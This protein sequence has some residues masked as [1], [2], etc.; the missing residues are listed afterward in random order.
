MSIKLISLSIFSFNGKV[1]A[2]KAISLSVFSFSLFAF[3]VPNI[4][5]FSFVNFCKNIENV[6]MKNINIVVPFSEAI[7][8]TFLYI[9]L[10]RLNILVL[11]TFLLMF[12]LTLSKG[13][14]VLSISPFKFSIQKLLCLLNSSLS[15]K[16]F[17]SNEYIEYVYGNSKSTFL[18]SRIS[19]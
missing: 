11:P 14:V 15:N 17:S 19:L 2:K 6:V 12:F 13:R 18:L 4:T 5:V 1:F 9:S 16:V 7:F 3:I 10:D 8:F